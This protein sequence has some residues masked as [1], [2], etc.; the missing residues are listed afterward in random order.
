MSQHDGSQAGPHTPGLRR[1]LA[2]R[3]LR[4]RLI[5]GL[6]ALLAV[7]C[8]VVGI[9]TYVALNRTLI[10]QVDAQLLA[11]GGRYASCMETNDDIEHAQEQGSPPPTAGPGGGQVGRLL[12]HRGRRRVGL[13]SPGFRRRRLRR[14]PGRQ[15]SP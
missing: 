3:T 5:T 7:A 6:V 15:S 8:A 14:H 2:G 4:W 10:N 13:G 9:V 1:W 11:A 12:D